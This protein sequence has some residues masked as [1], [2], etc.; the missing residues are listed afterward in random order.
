MNE[1]EYLEIVGSIKNEEVAEIMFEALC[2]LHR[3]L[4]AGS[5]SMTDAESGSYDLFKAFFKMYNTIYHLSNKIPYFYR[6]DIEYID[7]RSIYALIRSCHEIYLTYTYINASI[8]AGGGEEERE[9]KYSAYR[10]SGALDSKQIYTRIKDFEGYKDRY[11]QDFPEIDEDIRTCRRAV[12]KS[13]IYKLLDEKIKKAVHSGHWKV[14]KKSKLGW[15]DLLDC[16][17]M[18]RVYGEFEYK[19]LSLYAHSS[20]ASLQLEAQHDYDMI[21][22]LAHLYKLAAFMCTTTV[23]TFGLP[24]LDKRTRALI[25]DLAVMGNSIVAKAEEIRREQQVTRPKTY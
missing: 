4:E 12:S 16:T 14:T 13:P 21:C 24:E 11:E 10:L 23:L 7:L 3:H 25:N 6:P 8:I 19:I 18:P 22:A 17:P 15:S 9:F 20:H 2:E 5:L 1:E